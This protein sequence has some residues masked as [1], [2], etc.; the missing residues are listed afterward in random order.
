MARLDIHGTVRYIPGPWGAARPAAGV[1]IKLIDVDVGNPSDTIWTGVTDAAGAFSGTTSDWRDTRSVTVGRGPAS[2]TTQVADPGDVLVLR[3]QVSQRIGARLF[4]V[5]LPF[6][7]APPGTP[8]PPLLLPWGPAGR[9]QILVNGTPVASLQAFATLL[10][11]VFNIGT[12]VARTQVQREITVSG[13]GVAMLRS[14][15]T[16]LEAKLRELE[17]FFQALR[18]RASG[19]V[20]RGGERMRSDSGNF[21]RNAN[22]AGAQA[23]D[24]ARTTVGSPVA[25][26]A[27]QDLTS[28][29]QKL[30]EQRQRLLAFVT[31]LEPAFHRAAVAADAAWQTAIAPLVR[32]VVQIMVTIVAVALQTVS[33]GA[34]TTVA[35]LAVAAVAA[36]V[37]AVTTVIQNLPALLRA[38]GANRAADDM[39]AFLNQNS[40]FGSVLMVVVVVCALIIVVAAA[41]ADAWAWAVERVIGPDGTEGL[42]FVFSR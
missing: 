14:E 27:Q 5:E 4:Q 28:T 22:R 21:A 15:F 34:G 33:L 37:V 30:E 20:L 31:A 39:D 38:A 13:E 41:P 40:W 6:I 25:N 8:Q 9:S 18:P 2:V 1:D 11:Q 35:A 23:F 12:A 42:R 26:Q 10:G 36:V 24:A 29:Q 16:Q 7:T 32:R 17:S 3:V 19:E